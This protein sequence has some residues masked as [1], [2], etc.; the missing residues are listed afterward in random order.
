MSQL[1][2]CPVT[3]I[4][5]VSIIDLKEFIIIL[6]YSEITV[7]CTFI[8]GT[9]FQYFSPICKKISQQQYTYRIKE[10]EERKK[11]RQSCVNP[12]IKEHC[13]TNGNNFLFFLMGFNFFFLHMKTKIRK[14]NC[15]WYEMGSL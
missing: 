9:M 13:I 2:S 5:L 15:I 8:Q 11:E 1:R 7:H 10:V 6:L 12:A 14:L 3:C 4:D